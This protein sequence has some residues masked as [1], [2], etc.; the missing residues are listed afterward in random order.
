MT[1]IYAFPGQCSI[2]TCKCNSD[3]TFHGYYISLKLYKG[4]S[5]YDSIAL[6]NIMYI[7]DRL[8]R[9][10]KDLPVQNRLQLERAIKRINYK[11]DQ[12]KIDGK[13]LTVSLPNFNEKQFFEIKMKE[14]Q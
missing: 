6:G 10:T 1:F 3:K 9:L 5:R 13:S 11:I 2:K 14:I 8:R 7:K 12:Y 4:Q